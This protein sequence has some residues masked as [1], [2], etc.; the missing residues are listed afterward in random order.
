MAN[1]MDLLGQMGLGLDDEEEEDSQLA[2]EPKPIPMS[3]WDDEEDPNL[4]PMIQAVRTEER[5]RRM[6]EMEEVTSHKT[7]RASTKRKRMKERPTLARRMKEC[8]PSLSKRWEE[9]SI[10]EP[11]RL[12]ERGF[13]LH[14][15]THLGQ[16]ASCVSM[17]AGAL[18]T[19]AISPDL[20]DDGQQTTL[21]R[22][23]ATWRKLWE[24]W[25]TRRPFHGAFKKRDKILLWIALIGVNFVAQH[26][27]WRHRAEVEIDYSGRAVNAKEDFSLHSHF[28]ALA[29]IL[30]GEPAEGTPEFVLTRS[31]LHLL[32]QK[33]LFE[34]V[35]RLAE[36]WNYVPVEMAGAMPK[37]NELNAVGAEPW[38]RRDSLV[39]LLNEIMLRAGLL[40]F[41]EFFDFEPDLDMMFQ[42]QVNEA[43]E[44][45]RIGN[46]NFLYE[47]M[48]RVEE[49]S[50]QLY[51]VRTELVSGL[52]FKMLHIEPQPPQAAPRQKVRAW[53]LAHYLDGRMS[54]EIGSRFEK[55]IYDWTILLSERRRFSDD[56]EDAEH[57][58]LNALNH[59][60][61][62]TGRKMAKIY[63]NKT[64]LAVFM[65][66]DSTIYVE[67]VRTLLTMI[68]LNFLC[69]SSTRALRFSHRLWF[70]GNGIDTR[71][72]KASESF[73][74]ANADNHF[75][76]TENVG[77]L[78]SE[79]SSMCRRNSRL[80]LIVR[81][82]G[83]WVLFV[84]C[85][86]N[87][88]TIIKKR[89]R[90]TDPRKPQAFSTLGEA[91]LEWLRLVRSCD[92]AFSRIEN[93]LFQTE[94]ALAEL[95]R[96]K[97]QGEQAED[98]DSKVNV[99]VVPLSS[100][101]GIEAKTADL[102]GV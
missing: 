10:E 5:L 50:L 23:V 2:P 70:V 85:W 21:R 24:V 29:R 77:Q 96:I 82:L 61:T 83:S 28:P 25:T 19:Q 14:F 26:K 71:S 99:R 97:E 4:A 68:A 84:P 44:K 65:Q 15:I 64:P 52:G 16:V 57:N 51:V 39:G 90:I 32:T 45:I 63:M 89:A 75:F 8:G 9:L 56:S 74:G 49:M 76:G 101:D 54:A 43:G 102:F 87:S 30:F 67:E 46:V 47:I 13:M 34:L 7:I 31:M 69:D 33:Q 80:P 91:F 17:T 79:L 58:N 22:M 95:K 12:T 11:L 60:R 53:L 41:V 81:I 100:R 78:Q 72:T 3:E 93:A 6:A 38:C 62:E 20:A 86:E 73:G 92:P 98:V 88:S 37:A 27:R 36:R 1:M 42:T 40:G 35:S 66:P 59:C 55:S 48:S 18:V 94:D